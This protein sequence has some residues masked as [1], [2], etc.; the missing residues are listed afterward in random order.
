MSD[1]G[2]VIRRKKEAAVSSTGTATHNATPLLS[3]ENRQPEDRHSVLSRCYQDRK[4]TSFRRTVDSHIFRRFVHCII[5]QVWDGCCSCGEGTHHWSRQPHRQPRHGRNT[6]QRRGAVLEAQERFVDVK[7]LREKSP[8]TMFFRR[9]IK[10]LK[11]D[12]DAYPDNMTC[13]PQS[14]RCIMH[15]HMNQLWSGASQ[16]K[17]DRFA[18][19]HTSADNECSKRVWRMPLS[20]ATSCQWNAADW[21]MT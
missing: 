7:T 8:L 3:K 5:Q 11:I 19:N 10:D 13:S 14:F 9:S 12:D 20:K 16:S 6:G 2:K 1:V 21:N 18:S 17:I 4:E 15:L